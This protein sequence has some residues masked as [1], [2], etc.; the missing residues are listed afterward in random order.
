MSR[1]VVLPPEAELL[2]DGSKL[3][4]WWHTVDE[5]GR[6]V[7]DL[8]PRA[9]SL[10]PGDRGFC[11]VRE[12]RDG[13][14]VLTTYGRSTG[15]C[16]DPIEKKPLNHFYPG[17]SILSFGTAGCNLGCKFCQNWDISKSR[18]VERLS[19]FA[20]PETIAEAARQHGCLSVAYTYNDPVI[21]AEYAID[22][23]KACRAVGVKSVAVTAGY[24]T[25]Q[26]RGPFFEYMDAANVDLKA[27]TEEFY[28]KLTY[29]HLQ[30]VL[31]TLAWLKRETDVWFEITNLII[32][33]END[34]VDELRRMCDWML[35]E[36]GRRGAAALHGLPPRLPHA[37]P[38]ADAAGDA[39]GGPRTG[40]AAGHQVRLRGQRGRRA[41][42]EHLLPA[43]RRLLIERNWYDLGVYRL[44]GDRCGHCGGRIAGRFAEPP[45]NWG[46]K[47]LPVRI[48][49]FAG[50]SLPDQQIPSPDGTCCPVAA[51]RRQAARTAGMH[52]LTTQK[53]RKDYGHDRT[54]RQPGRGDRSAPG[55]A[56]HPGP[57]SG[58]PSGGVRGR[59]GR[60]AGPPVP[61]ERSGLAGAAQ[62]T[63]M[64]AFV[65]LRR[66]GQ[67][68]ACCGMLGMPMPLA[69]AVQHAA[70]RTATEDSRFPTISPTE[71]PHLHLDVTL[72]YGFQP[73]TAQGAERI[74]EVEV[75]RHGLQI[76]RGGAAGLLLPSVATDHGWD[77]ETFLQQVCRKAGLPTTAWMADDAELLKFE[78]HMI[79]GRLRPGG[80]GRRGPREAAAL[81]ARRNCSSWPTN[82]GATCWPW[83]KAPRPTTTCPAARTARSRRWPL[84]VRYADD[85][86]PLRFSQM[87]LRPGVPLQAT[88][89]Q[90]CEAAAKALARL[91]LG[92][93]AL[94]RLRLDLTVLY[95]P[96]M[97]GMV[98]DP[99]LSGIDPARRAVLV[100]EQGKTAWVFDPEQVAAG[101]AGRRPRARPR[102]PCRTRPSVFS[103]A[104]LSTEPARRSRSVPRPAAGGRR[105]ARRPSPGM[106]YPAERR[107]SWTSMVDRMLANGTT[108]PGNVAGHHGAARRAD[109][110]RPAGGGHVPARGDPGDG[111]PDRPEAHAAGRRVGGGA[112][113]GLVAAGARSASDPELARGWPR[114]SRAWN[115][116]RRPTSRSTPWKSSCRSWRSWRRRRRVVGIAVGAGDLARCRQFAAGLADAIRGTAAPAAAADLDR[117]E[118]LR[119]RRREPA[120]GRNRP[121]VRR[122]AGP[123]AGLRDGRQPLRHQHVRRAPGGDRAGDAAAAGLAH[124]AANAWATP[125]APTSP[126]TPA[127][128]SATPACCS[129]PRA[130]GWELAGFAKS[131]M[132]DAVVLKNA[133]EGGQAGPGSSSVGSSSATG[134]ERDTN[135]SV[136]P[137]RG[138]SA[139]GRAQG[140]AHAQR[141]ALY[142][143]QATDAA[144]IAGP[145][146]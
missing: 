72:L 134:G 60:R 1:V 9:C 94:N 83:S 27:F 136:R 62:Q 139:A 54:S 35:A 78:G 122:D 48:A 125:P 61:A 140:R 64:G 76:R 55:P 92:R 33:Q 18:E 112:A 116:T 37:G 45:G 95:D 28:F 86:P 73:I 91:R 131:G 144:Q 14:M 69:Q 30:P 58:H 99:D 24:I 17:T 31:D 7:C 63:V 146:L 67:L 145:L 16:I 21:W 71:L 84:A 103:L 133:G 81:F 135:G 123:G 2:A 120:A 111:D 49:Q 13:Q 87:S 79:R 114:P 20:T 129:A 113:R 70:Q 3:G 117:H 34:S 110:L 29:S 74:Q 124:A 100:I 4:G 57:G 36:R 12:N 11:F 88:L 137:P 10:K 109:L 80:A 38:A 106:F 15:F 8:C 93:A 142:T 119:Q 59:Q 65:T 143:V 101:V 115:W 104:A 118:P 126:A 68:R 85:Q 39:A 90:L 53:Q 66:K 127:A 138:T 5:T 42:P 51:D 32:P 46:R 130:C 96:A 107:T 98:A 50:P 141:P 25:P 56:T 75:G 22:V 89:F 121:A 105:A 77:A 26:S 47:R 102:S 128:W 19:E 44:Q 82:A 23:A 108:Q 132:P 40:A 52:R 6:I 43:L 41:A 97:H